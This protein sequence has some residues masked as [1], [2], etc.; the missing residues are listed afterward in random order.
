MLYDFPKLCLRARAE[1]FM[2]LILHAHKSWA[3]ECSQQDVALRSPST[4]PGP[5][6]VFIP[7]PT[8]W[9]N[10]QVL[11]GFALQARVQLASLVPPAASAVVCL[12]CLFFF[13]G[14][15]ISA[16]W[17]CFAGTGPACQPGATSSVSISSAGSISDESS[18]GSSTVRSG[19]S[20]FSKPPANSARLRTEQQCRPLQK[21]ESREEKRQ[22]LRRLHLLRECLGAWGVRDPKLLALLGG[23]KRRRPQ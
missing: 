7:G 12:A 16:C 13:L 3:C 5:C 6:L 18:G 11:A 22:H 1:S 23:Q 19:T 2:L 17:L 21:A 15:H 14:Q 9:A 20:T 10:T 4:Q 8:P